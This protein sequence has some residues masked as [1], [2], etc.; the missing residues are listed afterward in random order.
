MKK[1]LEAELISIAHRILKLKNK[2]ELRQLHLETQKLY[3]KLTVLQFVENHFSETKPT[4]GKS[5]WEEKVA[6]AFEE[7]DTTLNEPLA[8]ITQEEPTENLEEQPIEIEETT[9]T[10]IEEMVAEELQEEAEE[11]E[12]E[13]LE[14]ESIDETIFIPHFEVEVETAAE[15][16]PEDEIPQQKME[17]K[18]ISLED[19]LGG[20]HQ[21]PVF[22]RV[23]SVIE[24]VNSDENADEETADLLFE[25][26]AD[27]SSETTEI[28]ESVNKVFTFGLNDRIAFEKQLFGGSSEDMNRVLSQ[29]ITYDTFQEVHVFIEEMVKPDYNNWE[30]KEEYAQRFME[31]IERKFS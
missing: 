28:K 20:M 30:G 27:E 17:S 4:I 22:E 16:L 15:S 14:E 29:L 23:E 12:E 3:E 8:I 2:S 21:E 19:L 31:L 11:A 13:E 26:D 5:E 24:S 9:E 10:E 25:I 7:M 1:K 6:E 18:Q